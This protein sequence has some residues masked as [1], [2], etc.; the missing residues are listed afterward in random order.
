[1]N[2]CDTPVLQRAIA[3]GLN[4]SAT[5]TAL[6]HKEKVTIMDIDEVTGVAEV[7]EAIA[8]QLGPGCVAPD[9]V[10]LRKSYCGTQAA[11]VALPPGAADKLIKAGKLRIGWVNCRVRLPIVRCYRCLEQGHIARSCKSTSDRSKQ[12]FQCGKEGH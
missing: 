6:T 5:V 8:V 11:T 10:K 1:M 7:I 2:Y 9:T 3:S 4:E 12:C